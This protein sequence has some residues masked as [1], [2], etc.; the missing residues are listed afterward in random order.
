[1][2][3][4][5]SSWNNVR[6]QKQQE[7]DFYDQEMERRKSDMINV[8]DTV[9]G[10]QRQKLDLVG[11]MRSMFDRILP[12]LA[13]NEYII[14][15]DKF[16]LINKPYPFDKITV[17]EIVKYLQTYKKYI[18]ASMVDLKKLKEDNLYDY[19]SLL[20]RENT[21]PTTKPEM[22]IPPKQSASPFAPIQTA[23]VQQSIA[24]QSIMQQSVSKPSTVQPESF[25]II[26][27]TPIHKVIPSI[28]STTDTASATI[29]AILAAIQQSSENV[30]SIPSVSYN[31]ENIAL[32]QEKSS[33]EK[34]TPVIKA[35]SDMHS[36][37][38]PIAASP[39]VTLDL[40]SSPTFH[41]INYVDTHS[42]TIDPSKPVY[43]TA[44]ICSESLA[45][46]YKMHS[47]PYVLMVINSKYKIPIY[48]RKKETGYYEFHKKKGPFYASR[49]DIQLF[50]HYN[51]R[52]QIN[53]KPTEI[54]HFLFETLVD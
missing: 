41:I 24:Q 15:I 38:T 49:I 27:S 48:L 25:P 11:K 17:E 23:Q 13:D 3:F 30:P 47:I 34:L 1:M 22:L 50:D 53:H 36:T 44:S 20:Q 19:Q 31:H 9:E 16:N 35:D 43:F 40:S 6:M 51:E 8:V 46:R 32:V 45:H 28:T 5:Q 39:V 10:Y 52:I 37:M 42:A 12:N 29:D 4:E 21:E 18:S 33:D 2:Y 7:K 54:F 26:Q 14:M